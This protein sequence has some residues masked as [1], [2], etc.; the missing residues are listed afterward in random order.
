[1]KTTRFPDAGT[2]R[3]VLLYVEQ[4]QNSF[5]LWGGGRDTV[6]AVRGFVGHPLL[7]HRTGAA[8]E[9]SSLQMSTITEGWG[10]QVA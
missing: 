1:M 9:L 2:R 5:G 6:R 8:S 10:L 4:S 3:V 7:V